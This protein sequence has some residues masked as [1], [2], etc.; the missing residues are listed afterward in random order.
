[1]SWQR[2]AG[3]T[4][5]FVG[6]VILMTIATFLYIDTEL[7]SLPAGEAELRGQLGE[8]FNF[9]LGWPVAAI[10]AVASMVVGVAALLV[11]Q[12][13]DLVE[14]LRFADE[15]ITAANRSFAAICRA[16]LELEK[17]GIDLERLSDRL[18]GEIADAYTENRPTGDVPAKDGDE[19]SEIWSDLAERPE[20]VAALDGIKPV[21]QQLLD[22]YYAA[23]SHPFTFRV[24]QNSISR[25]AQDRE[26]MLLAAR[27]IYDQ[28]GVSCQERNA[29]LF[30]FTEEDYRMLESG[31]WRPLA[32]TALSVLD[33]LSDLIDRTT[34]LELALAWHVTPT[35]N[36]I[37]F[38]GALV[39]HD[40]I[41]GVAPAPILNLG[42]GLLLTIYQSLPSRSVLEETIGQIFPP[43]E[44]RQVQKR[45]YSIQSGG[46]PHRY[47]PPRFRRYFESE[48]VAP[49]VSR[50]VYVQDA[51][52][53][54]HYLDPEEDRFVLTDA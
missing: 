10:S 44:A 18:G 2:L 6:V 46:D 31:Q 1:M 47:L 27:S 37:E 8:H 28:L 33:E 40:R 4:L 26:N 22:T 43:S 9:A 20:I 48:A 36:P 13:Q 42:Y 49:L 24:M 29:R 11:T 39:W 23:V 21:L 14:N 15:R 16:L 45:L 51:D 30:A 54:P 53:L 17:V 5:V 19:V 32:M 35:R 50:F 41:A 34:P 7:R 12:R 38:L 25:A 52:E 3:L